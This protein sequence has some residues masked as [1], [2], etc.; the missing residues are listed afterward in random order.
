MRRGSRRI[1]IVR[2]DGLGGWVCVVVLLVRLYR[3]L[4]HLP[5]DRRP[6]RRPL[7]L[8]RRGIEL[9]SPRTVLRNPGCRVSLS[10]WGQGKL[11]V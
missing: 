1:V 11:G 3:P 8:Q 4:C 2:V 5:L 10:L 9:V 7:Y 6:L